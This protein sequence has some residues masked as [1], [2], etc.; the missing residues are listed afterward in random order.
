MSAGSGPFPFTTSVTPVTVVEGVLGSREAGCINTGAASSSGTTTGG[1]HKLDT[2]TSE[3][4]VSSG[5]ITMNKPNLHLDAVLCNLHEMRDRKKGEMDLLSVQAK[6]PS[7]F[8]NKAR[9]M[10]AE[11]IAQQ[12]EHVEGVV[13]SSVKA[14]NKDHMLPSYAPI[15]GDPLPMNQEVIDCLKWGPASVEHYEDFDEPTMLRVFGPLNERNEVVPRDYTHRCDLLPRD[16]EIF[17]LENLSDGSSTVPSSQWELVDQVD[18]VDSRLPRNGLWAHGLKIATVSDKA[19]EFVLVITNALDGVQLLGNHD[20]VDG[21]ENESLVGNAQYFA[22]K[23]LQ[24]PELKAIWDN[25]LQMNDSG[26]LTPALCTV[27]EDL[28][29]KQL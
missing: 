22:S 16:L 6:N 7:M 21:M 23:N 17:I 15:A 4:L 13:P 28:Q 1:A 14:L 9:L 27:L 26:E 25:A 5:D 19:K 11:S 24:D 2:H 12:Y 10:S 8:T 3:Q 18:G 29:Y 20:F